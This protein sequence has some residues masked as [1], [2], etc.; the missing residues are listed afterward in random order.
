MQ[1]Q[2]KAQQKAW[3]NAEQKVC[4]VQGAARGGIQGAARGRV[5][6]MVRA[7]CPL[8]LPAGHLRW[9][10]TESPTDAPTESP[11]ESLLRIRRPMRRPSRPLSLV[12]HRT[13]LIF[14]V[15]IIWD[16]L[17]SCV[18]FGGSQWI[19]AVFWVLG[20]GSQHISGFGMMIPVGSWATAPPAVIGIAAG[21]P[22]G[23]PAVNLTVGFGGALGTPHR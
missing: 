15:N 14:E 22:C 1:A 20:S 11:T 23:Y 18:F 5:Q 19:R 21:E 4:R 16:H 10:A 3:L 8:L 6:G 7:M 12:Q 13:I 17:G 9:A 2:L